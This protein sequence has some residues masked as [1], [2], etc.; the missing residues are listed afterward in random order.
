MNHETPPSGF[1]GGRGIFQISERGMGMNERRRSSQ[2]AL[3]ST[4]LRV[5]GLVF[6]IAGMIGRGIIQNAVLG[7]GSVTTQE[8][9]QAME[10]DGNVVHYASAAIIL[11]G[12][13]TCAVPI[14]AFLL[15]EG[16]RHTSNFKAY[17]L[18][19]LGVALLAEIPFNLVCRSQV[20]DFDYRNPAFALVLGLVMLYFYDRYPGFSAG[21]IGAKAAV[22]VGAFLWVQMLRVQD[23][24][25]LL[26]MVA[27]LWALRNKSVIRPLAAAVAAFACSLFSPYYMVAPISVVAI[28]LYSG[29]RG[30]ENKWANYLS[31]PVLLLAVGIAAVVMK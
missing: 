4:G 13:E 12:I 1:P 23:G 31:Y 16:F 28:H 15:V 11:Q 22:S 8:L 7:I 6:L 21:S 29:E 2:L 19:V 24:A 26:V 14:F 17:I 25:P 20:F 9:L 27:V 5:W 30:A 18:R 10:M 3:T